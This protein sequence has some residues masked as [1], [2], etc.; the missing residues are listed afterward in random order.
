M[1]MKGIYLF[2][3]IEIGCLGQNS[4]IEKK[5]RAQHKILNKHFNC[6]LIVLPEIVYEETIKEKIYRRLPFTP[7]W[8][9]W[10][11][12]EEFREISFL[13]LRETYYDYSFVKYL[14][15]IRKTNRNIKIILEIPTYPPQPKKW[16]IKTAPY[17]FKDVFWGRLSR[18]YIDSIV[19]FYGY[20]KIDGVPCI[21]TI[22]GFDFDSVKLETNV[23]DT[24]RIELL[25]VAV[26]AYWH[27]YDRVIKGLHQ[28]YLNGG[29]LDFLY[30]IIG[31]P[32]PEY[33]EMVEKYNL[34]NHVI[35]HGKLHG[36]D[37]NEIYS[38]CTLAIDVLGGH[39]KGYPISSSLKSRE[40]GA[41]GLPIVT[42][43]PID[44]LN[45]KSK[46]QYIVP[47]DDTPIDFVE[48]GDYYHRFYEGK[49]ISAVRKEIR[50]NAQA[51]CDMSVSMEP[52]IQWI[53]NNCRSLKDN[54]EDK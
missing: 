17:I 40:Y 14:K 38:R 2:A 16:N 53:D 19:N 11:Y 3:P 27:G 22:N 28:Y 44:Y 35:I 41:W 1:R 12:H 9:N 50:E 21:K 42:S 37:L 33:I 10:E 26:N 6:R 20:D 29:N 36:E 49:E 47:Y 8:R 34:N 48:I 54:N 23:Q 25:S 13:Y 51:L 45:K 5:V 52:I 30:H 7:G 32:L 43:S 46:Y 4:G 39:R 24:N 15:K 31:S 18:N